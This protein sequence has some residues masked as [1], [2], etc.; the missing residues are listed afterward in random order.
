MGSQANADGAGIGVAKRRRFVASAAGRVAVLIGIG[1]VAWAVLWNSGVARV[2]YDTLWYATFTYE[3]AGVPQEASWARSWDLL[4]RYGGAR[5]ADSLPHAANGSW[6]DGWDD[7]SRARW[8]GI[9]AMRPI[10]PVLGAAVFPVLGTDSPVLVSVLAVV[11]L[12]LAAWLIVR[13]IAGA[14]A[15]ALLLLATPVNPFINKELLSLAPDGLAISLWLVALGCS[16][17]YLI[18]G[19]RA[20]VAAAGVATLVLAFDRPSALLVPAILG[21]GAVLAALL[22]GPWRRFIVAAFATGIGAG[23]FTIWAA[24]LRYPSFGDFLQDLPTHHF[25]DPDI[26]N[27]IGFMLHYAKALVLQVPGEMVHQPLVPLAIVLGAAGLLIV[28]RWWTVPFLL[29]M[30]AVA[31]LALAHP[32]RTEV[33]RTLAPGWL[34]VELGLGILAS[35]AV[36]RVLTGRR[37][38]A[39]ERELEVSGVALAPGDV[40]LSVAAPPAGGPAGG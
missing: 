35:V 24:I 27:P 15:T 37:G 36:T 39:L 22:R 34:S 3:D 2:R 16:A 12:V 4:A 23:L 28:R 10:M 11:L 13:P 1:V 38:T 29:A 7:P 40:A 26:A 6:F 30:P 19:G 17:R 31:A 33:E 25:V 9:Y 5:F 32:V 18:S 14:R 8:I 20:W 21:G